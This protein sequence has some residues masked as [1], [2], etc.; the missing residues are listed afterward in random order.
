MDKDPTRFD[1]E[2]EDY[3]RKPRYATVARV[4]GAVRKRRKKPVR[5]NPLPSEP[6]SDESLLLAWLFERIAAKVVARDRQITQNVCRANVAGLLHGRCESEPGPMR[7]AELAEYAANNP[8]DVDLE[9]I[10]TK[11]SPRSFGS[12]WSYRPA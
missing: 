4:E 12:R 11:V 6:P 1:G 7:L 10:R 2:S 5:H 9:I 8:D 3:R